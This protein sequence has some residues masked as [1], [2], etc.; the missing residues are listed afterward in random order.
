MNYV[1]DIVSFK[2]F[3]NQSKLNK[4]KLDAIDNKGLEWFLDYFLVF[5]SIF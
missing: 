2:V 5:R 3:E 1:D 4:I